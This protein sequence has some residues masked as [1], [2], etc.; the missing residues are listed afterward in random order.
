MDLAGVWIAAVV[1]VMYGVRSSSL[2]DVPSL[3]HKRKFY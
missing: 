3:S 2:C 1:D